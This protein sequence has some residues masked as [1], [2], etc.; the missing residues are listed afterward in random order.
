MA[1]QL[2]AAGQKTALLALFDSVPPT[3]EG[4]FDFTYLLTALARELSIQLGAS[5]SLTTGD[6]ADLTEAD[7]CAKVLD[8]M[9]RAGVDTRVGNVDL[10][11]DSLG[12]IVRA[13]KS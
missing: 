3:V 8:L 10:S 11:I 4:T 6:L 5:I 9:A 2:A 7:Q 13:I 1:Q 12:E